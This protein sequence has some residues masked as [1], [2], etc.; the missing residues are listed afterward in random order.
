MFEPDTDDPFA[1]FDAWFADAEASEPT[2]PNAMS[3]AT[4][5]AAGRPSVRILL[6]KEADSRGFVFYTNFESRKGGELTVNPFAALCFHWKT[7]KRQVRVEGP[8]GKV[9]DEEADAY[10]ASRARVSQLGA[11]ASQ[12]SRPLSGRDALMSAVEKFDA[13]YADRDVPRPPYWTG[14]RLVPLRIEFWQDGANRLH[15]RFLFSRPSEGQPWTV[16]RL[17]P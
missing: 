17:N 14:A 5:D 11:W 7:L 10:F 3:V 16:A 6:L 15:D 8:I 1:L 13:D 9:T 12:Q 4:A 2:D